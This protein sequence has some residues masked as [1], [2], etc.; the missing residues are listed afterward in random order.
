VPREA[1]MRTV[2][3]LAV[4]FRFFLFVGLYPLYEVLRDF[5]RASA[6]EKQEM[7]TPDSS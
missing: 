2:I 3:S 1:S 5:V 4:V 6:R 7:N